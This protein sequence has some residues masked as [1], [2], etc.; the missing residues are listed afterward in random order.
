MLQELRFPAIGALCD[1]LIRM[2]LDPKRADCSATNIVV[3]DVAQNR[4]PKGVAAC[5]SGSESL[6]FDWGEQV[7]RRVLLCHL[8]L[9]GPSSDVVFLDVMSDAPKSAFD[10][11]SGKVLGSLAIVR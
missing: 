5:E 6:T 11:V 3:S 7:R 2:Q 4:L 8:P 9:T 1:L 10:Q